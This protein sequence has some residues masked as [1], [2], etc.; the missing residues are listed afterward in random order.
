MFTSGL[1]LAIVAPA[2]AAAGHMIESGSLASYTVLGVAGAIA[3]AAFVVLRR[4]T[5]RIQH[6]ISDPLHLLAVAV[7]VGL[8]VLYCYISERTY[9]GP[10]VLYVS[11]GMALI[12]GAFLNDRQKGF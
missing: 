12:A 11:I 9:V 8:F 3:I 10:F 2:I 5:K 4:A 1:L 7:A 6:I